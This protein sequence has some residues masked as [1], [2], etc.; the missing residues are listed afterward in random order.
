MHEVLSK[1]LVTP[2]YRQNALAFAMVLLVAG[3]F[4]RNDDHIALA[5]EAVRTPFLL[6][7]Y[8]LIWLLYSLFATR[9][10]VSQIH[11]YDV[12]LL[13]RLIPRPRR[14]WGLWRIQISLLLPVIAYGLFVC[15]VGWKQQLP[16]T[17]AV[18]LG[19]LLLLSLGTLAWY[20]YALRHPHPVGLLAGWSGTL[21]RRFQT[22]YWL[23]GIR[24][25]LANVATVFWRTKIATSLVWLG[26]L[27][28]YATDHYQI[29]LF[30]T[31]DYDLRLIG[32]G[33]LIVGLSQAALVYELYR[34]EHERLRLYRN[35][36]V[37][38][39]VRWARYVGQ[40]ALL[41]LPEVLLFFYHLPVGEPVWWS[42][43]ALAFAISLPALL[44]GLFLRV[45][46]HFERNLPH[47]YILMITYFL[48]IMFRIPLWLL[49]GTNFAAAGWL[50]WRYYWQSSWKEE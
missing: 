14:L 48:L 10:A 23:F 11:R 29:N 24:H 28:L 22:P 33:G 45:P 26:I 16:A 49:A 43:G 31:P 2:F 46:R 47:L 30:R 1:T 38:D 17:V 32:L 27:K 13:L 35:M 18:V 37:S 39:W 25:L 7:G 36:P 9:F 50:F 34:F 6:A 41:L 44:Y 8:G 21:R 20:E 42:V 3:G 40:F 19:G 5:Q 12:L 15:W 4:M